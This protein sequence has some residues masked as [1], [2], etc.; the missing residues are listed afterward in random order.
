[1]NN[2]IQPALQ[3]CICFAADDNYAPYLRTAIY[4]LLCNRNVQ[5]SYDIIILHTNITQDKRRKILDLLQGQ[6]G[7]SIRFIDVSDM[8]A[9]VEYEFVA[10]Y[11]IATNY[12]LFLFSEI[13]SAYHRMI[14]L[15]C[16]TI[17][18]GDISELFTMDMEGKMVAAVEDIGMRW[19]SYAKRPLYIDGHI[20]YT[21]E[22]YRKFALGM[23]EPLKYFNAGVILFDL[24]RCRRSYRFQ[25]VAD[26]LHQKQFAFNDQDTLNILCD[27]Q[28]KMLDCEWNYQNNIEVYL[29]TGNPKLIQLIRDVKRTQYQ[30]IH[31]IG[32]KKPWN[33]EVF[34]GSYYKQYEKQLEK[35]KTNETQDV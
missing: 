16:D 3:V 35:E 27:G 20:P 12:R 30:I 31:F 4:S 33:E 7:V 10:Y 6:S 11:S 1:M 2:I 24:D 28:V 19:L 9:S 21:A 26:I 8:E 29:S 14:Y 17:I 23:K 18:L 15:D 22:N 13:F 25:E 5:Y 34:L 32:R